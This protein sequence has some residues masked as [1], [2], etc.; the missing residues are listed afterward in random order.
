MAE[1]L[2][3]A[4]RRDTTDDF[5]SKFYFSGKIW[6]RRV[7]KGTTGDTEESV[8]KKDCLG[9]VPREIFSGTGAVNVW[10]AAETLPPREN[11]GRQDFSEG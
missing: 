1:G 5:Y 8:K 3:M 10:P 6:G 7:E 11:R 2:G 9:K 4:G